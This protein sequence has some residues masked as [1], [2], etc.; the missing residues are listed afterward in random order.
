M[1]LTLSLL[2]ACTQTG[3]IELGGPKDGR[4]P[5][6]DTDLGG[7]DSGAAMGD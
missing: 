1:I 2:F 7:D 6:S 5:V 3:S 4:P